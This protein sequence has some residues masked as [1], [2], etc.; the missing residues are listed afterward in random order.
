MRADLPADVVELIVAHHAASRLQ[1]AW[2][3]WRLYA[4]A[5]RPAWRAVRLPTAAWRALFPYARVRR[6]WRVEPESWRAPEDLDAVVREARAGLW[7][8]RDGA[9]IFAP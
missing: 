6:E 2:T 3:R 8:P 7:G 5:R 1:R 9:S 4:H